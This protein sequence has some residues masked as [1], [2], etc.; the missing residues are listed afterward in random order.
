MAENHFSFNQIFIYELAV[1]N[2]LLNVFTDKH[3]IL[4]GKNRH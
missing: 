2:I 3:W 1:L 4:K